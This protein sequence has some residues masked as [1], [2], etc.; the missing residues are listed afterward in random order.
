MKPYYEH[1]GITIYHGDCREVLPSLPANSIESIVTDPPYELG[2]MGKKWDS[3]GIAFNVAVWQECLRVL[4]PGGHLLA[5][6]GTRTHHRMVCAIEDAGFEIRDQIDWLYGSGFPKSLDVS[7]AID[8]IKGTEIQ[9]ETYRRNGGGYNGKGKHIGQ[10]TTTSGVGIRPIASTPEAQAQ[11]WDG[12]GTALKPAHE[13]IC[14]ARKPLSEPTVAENV[15]KWGTGA[16]N[17]DACRIGTDWITK[18]PT[19]MSKNTK[20]AQDAWTKN[21]LI[22]ERRT[23]QGRWPANVLFDEEAAAMLDEQSG[24][25]QSK[26]SQRGK[27]EIFKK[28]NGWIGESTERGHNNSGGAS[29]FFYV[30]KASKKERGKGNDHPTVKPLQLMRYLVK[31]VTPPDGT[32]LDPF[33]GSGT[34]LEAA[35]NLGRKAI[36]IEIEE[37]YCEIAAKRLQQEVLLQ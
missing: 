34:T 11:Q 21:N 28:P 6:G 9:Y 35:R 2:F 17:I 24:Y 33:M 27:V 25:T 23:Y 1:N 20:Y 10:I 7:K 16:L 3:T 18:I 13:P 36:G 32:V 26:Q 4:K 14:L 5:F 19:N 12:W 29:R 31:L 8:K 30:A 15:L 37:R 22:G